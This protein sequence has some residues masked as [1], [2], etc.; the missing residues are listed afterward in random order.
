MAPYALLPGFWSGAW[1]RLPRLHMLRGFPM[2]RLRAKAAASPA[3]RHTA[4]DG[5]DCRELPGW[6]WPMFDRPGE[7]AAI[8]RRAG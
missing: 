3:F 6:R 5:L 4:T 7:L 8:L 1:E 2:E